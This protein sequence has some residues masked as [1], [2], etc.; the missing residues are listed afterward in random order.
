MDSG[1]NGG[2]SGPDTHLLSVVPNA[3]VD[4]TGISGEPI[5]QLQLVKCAAAVEMLDEV[6]IIL[7]MSQYTH[8]PTGKTI[9]SKS[10]LE[11]FGCSVHDSS[12]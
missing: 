6:M 3:H 9:H 8:A 2:M 10:Q 1:A 11:H 4:N 7:I 5:E 12:R